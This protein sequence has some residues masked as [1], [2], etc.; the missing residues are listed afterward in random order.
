MFC[1]K[2][3]KEIS[4]SDKFCP[5][6][7]TP[8]AAPAEQAFTASETPVNA[9]P[10]ASEA[11]FVSETPAPTYATN[12]AGFYQAPAEAPEAAPKKKR[13]KKGLVIGIIA[14]ALAAV[15]ALGFVFWPQLSNLWNKMTSSPE[16]YFQAALS[17][18]ADEMTDGAFKSFDMMGKDVTSKGSLSLELGKELTSILAMS[19]EDL[20]WL[21]DIS[22][23][24][25]GI[26]SG[27]QSTTNVAF[28]IGDTKILSPFITIDNEGKM[29]YLSIPELSDTPIGISL[30][31]MEFDQF[32]AMTNKMN[33]LLQMLPE[34]KVLEKTLN[35]C[36]DAVITSITD[37]EEE[38]DDLKVGDISE[39]CTLL[40]AKITPQVVAKAIT[41]LSEVI[42]KDEGA[43]EI[44]RTIAEYTGEDEDEILDDI[45]ESMEEAAADMEDEDSDEHIPFKLWVN[46]KGDISGFEFGND[47]TL[48][49]C[50]TPHDGGD[51]T[52]EA[53][54][55]S[56]GTVFTIEGEGNSDSFDVSVNIDKNEIIVVKGSDISTSKN[57]AEGRFSLSLGDDA[58]DYMS[59]GDSDMAQT[60]NM[61][62]GYALFIDVAGDDDSM[63]CS[64]GVE[65]KSAGS[66]LFAIKYEASIEEG[67]ENVVIPDDYVDVEDEDALIDWAE[68]L[69]SDAIM[70]NLKDAGVSEEFIESFIESF[71]S[72]FSASDSL[73]YD[74]YYGYD[75]YYDYGDYD[76]YYDYDGYY[77][78]E[79]D[80]DIYDDYYDDY[81]YEGSWT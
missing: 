59:E 42:E 43:R 52:I 47:E 48:I 75:E 50:Y 55:E 49:Y 30:A 46:S 11:A 54:V 65:T 32:S 44:I 21:S 64:I 6:C 24:F 3:G 22:F 10:A 29:L 35:S 58:I 71:T 73:G 37:V 70:E 57:G 8:V 53:G 41:S 38:S 51:Y 60:M 5:I 81:D 4:P 18:A 1:L 27:D 15:V 66:V 31:S 39:G 7:G 74:D 69:D 16:E 72:A 67:A 34:S 56:Y 9:A 26:T 68:G 19:G 28:K 61:I 33:E 14:A 17:N 36:I 2:C 20:D 40:T 79:Y 23:D 45:I 62:K 63:E 78:Y 13:S 76:D 25:S 77:D 12:T 80:Y